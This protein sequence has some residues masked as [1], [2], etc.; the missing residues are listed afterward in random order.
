MVALESISI[1]NLNEFGRSKLEVDSYEKSR[2][3]ENP[4]HELNLF[5]YK[6][7]SSSNNKISSQSLFKLEKKRKI[8]PYQDEIYVI[9]MNPW[10]HN[11]EFF[12]SVH[13]IPK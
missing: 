10:F 4:K 5:P 2:D 12:L 1:G 3:S 13:N 8:K 9:K 6:E 11:L 7:K